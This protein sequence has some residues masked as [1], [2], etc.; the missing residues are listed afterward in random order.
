VRANLPYY[1]LWRSRER[2]YQV[3]PYPIHSHLV[4]FLGSRS[5]LKDTYR[6]ERATST[7]QCV[8]G[9]EA[10][11]I[12]DD[13]DEAFPYSL[14]HLL[15]RLARQQA[16]PPYRY[17]HPLYSFPYLRPISII[18]LSGKC[19]IKGSLRGKQVYARACDSRGGFAPKW[20][21]LPLFTEMPRRGV[22]GKWAFRR[23]T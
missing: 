8:I 17:V 14:Q 10:W 11:L 6:S 16:V 18:S 12:S 23:I 9:Q 15:D 3:L 5:V 19:I 1:Y 20:L 4:R 7:I 2:I 13:R 21:T 22:L